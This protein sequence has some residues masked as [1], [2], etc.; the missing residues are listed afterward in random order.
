[1]RNRLKN[2]CVLLRFSRLVRSIVPGCGPNRSC[3]ATPASDGCEVTALFGTTSAIV[4]SVL[5]VRRG[6]KE[7]WAEVQER[8][9]LL[10]A[11]SVGR[12]LGREEKVL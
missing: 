2:P 4:P 11:R 12:R 3:V 7:V 5:G 9:T 6:V 10:G 1:M 8:N